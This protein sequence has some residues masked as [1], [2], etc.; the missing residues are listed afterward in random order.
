MNLCIL[1]NHQY[2]LNYHLS[3]LFHFF[4]TE[5]TAQASENAGTEKHDRH[6]GAGSIPGQPVKNRLK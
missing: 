2:L 4:I 6:P 1:K 3:I 5:E